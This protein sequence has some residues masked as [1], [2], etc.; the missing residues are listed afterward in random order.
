MRPTLESRRCLARVALMVALTVTLVACGGGGG[1]TA[2]AAPAL[3]AP[4]LT[5][6]DAFTLTKDAVADTL[7][8][9]NA[10]G[11]PQTGGCTAVGLPDGLV[12]G[13]S[14]NGES[15]AIS[16]APSAVTSGVV[17]VMVT[18]VNTAGR[19][20]A[21]VMLTVVAEP[22]VATLLAPATAPTLTVGAVIAGTEAIVISAGAHS[23]VADSCTFVAASQSPAVGESLARL[24]GL[25]ITTSA[26][27]A[28]G[29]DGCLIA[30]TLT[31]ATAL[32][33][34]ERT[35][36]VRARGAVGEG[37]TVTLTVTL[38]VKVL[39]ATRPPMLPVV[40]VTANAV[41]G[42]AL[43]ATLTVANAEGGADITE[44]YFLDGSNDDAQV[45]DLD[46][47]AIEAAEDGR[48]CLIT[49][50]PLGAGVKTLK[51]RARSA[52]DMDEATVIITVVATV[53]PV[54]AVAPA[55]VDA[56]LNTMIETITIRNNTATTPL[57]AGS[58]VLVSDTGV[59]LRELANTNTDSSGGGSDYT[60]N[61]LTLATDVEANACTVG[62]VPD[63]RGDNILRVRADIDG[64]M[65]NVVV[66]TFTVRQDERIGFVDDGVVK[67]YGD[68][69]FVYVATA[70]S[71]AVD[72]AWAS[73]DPMVATVDS[74]SGTVTILTVGTTE[75]S[76]S[77]AEDS[78]Y[79]AA[80]GVY[81]LTVN[82][83]QPDLPATFMFSAV[84]GVAVAPQSIATAGAGT[85]DITS[86]FFIDSLGAEVATLSGLSGLSGLS[87][88]SA[89]GIATAA[90]SRAC[91]I[92]GTLATTSSTT[93]PTTGMQTF[94]VRAQSAFGFDETAVTVT[95]EPKRLNLVAGVD[96]GRSHTCA[97]SAGGDLYCWGD[98]A[99]NSLG[100]DNTSDRTTPILVDNTNDRAAPAQVDDIAPW[101]Q[102][103]AGLSH[104]CAVAADSKLY[105]WGDGDDGK[106]GHGDVNARTTPTRVGSDANWVQVSVNS[107]HSCAVRTDGEI[108]CWGDGREGR[109]GLGSDTSDRT[110]PNRVGSVSNW[111][112]VSAGNSHT[113]GVRSSGRLYCWGDGANGRLGRDSNRDRL[114]P[115]RVG[116]AEDWTQVSAGASHTC[117][118][119]TDAELYC[120]GNGDSGRLGLD[121]DKD[122]TT[123]TRVGT[124]AHWTQVSA[125]AF[126]TCA[127]NDAGQLRCWGSGDDGRLGLGDNDDRDTPEV[128][129]VLRTPNA[130]PNLADIDGGT[131]EAGQ[132]IAPII[133]VNSGGDVQPGGCAI[134][135]NAGK[136]FLPRGLRLHAAVSGPSVTCQI[137]GQLQTAVN[138]D[139]YYI[140]ATNA[141]GTSSV[142][143][144]VSFQI[145][146]ASPLITDITVSHTF[147]AELAIEPV[148][149]TNTGLSVVDGGCTVKPALPLGLNAV[150]IDDN[151][152]Q[153]C[154]VT[155]MPS[156][157]SVR[158]TY[159]MTAA[160]ANGKTHRAS[161]SIEVKPGPLANVRQIS[162]GR[163]HT[164]AISAT[165][166]LYCWGANDN[167]R[168]GRGIDGQ[169]FV[170]AWVGTTAGATQVS[171]GGH[172]SCAINDAG[173]LYCWGSG[174]D[175]QLGL[176]DGVDR[177]IPNR[178]GATIGWA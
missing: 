166:E 33:A 170:A 74:A 96:T 52:D 116:S 95:V 144:G 64:R 107:S 42:V 2:V 119:N 176:G 79:K 118:V 90:D 80:R 4:S 157:R 136:P 121:S 171:A 50:T 57:R 45:T 55:T 8:F 54:L 128:V 167:G 169:S 78:S 34:A 1:A 159:V 5:S 178:V 127:I 146:I 134:D 68:L 73:S 17:T 135:A 98:G 94:T 81:M 31:P 18:A 12:A 147:T 84:D 7:V 89:L 53:S 27:G 115:F 32:D 131:L 43:A 106:L 99:N 46:G 109:L 130:V 151:G 30:G 92:T 82:P 77:R 174:F 103:S 152:K 100:L 14:A 41:D 72:F 59:V 143:A 113:C 19:S 108:H 104:T 63:T 47:L 173:E 83:V 133:L 35:Y 87:P 16:G 22:A 175:G 125:R 149:Y 160:S 142:A 145:I 163:T 61:G 69:P 56:T 117:A 158:Q 138:T 11:A 172:H 25:T 60:V 65:S 48:A 44:C 168:L 49:G 140:T 102:V 150:H 75:I 26:G 124:A 51:I 164:C 132:V 161:V 38:T 36:T 85:A 23:L 137:T 39:L 86:C 21:N 67:I 76:A 70:D 126:H 29:T 24:D 6:L 110:S 139:T 71:G 62:G 10:G 9:A 13:L 105:C 97:V 20:V 165:E 123:P 3:T 58:C 162:N 148:I 37:A 120:W 93:S 153:T 101:T 66:L 28:A 155:G 15:C 154:A 111:T 40:D 129:T 91:E 112:Q 114:L 177:N 156:M 88:L 122:R 141:V